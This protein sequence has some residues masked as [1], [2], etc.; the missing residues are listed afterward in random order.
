MLALSLGLK[1]GVEFAVSDGCQ[2]VAIEGC[3]ER[4]RGGLGCSGVGLGRVG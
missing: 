3:D 2:R 4:D 1:F